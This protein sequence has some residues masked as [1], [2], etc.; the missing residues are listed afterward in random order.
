MIRKILYILV[1]KGKYFIF[2]VNEFLLKFGNNIYCIG[3]IK[4]NKH[5]KSINVLF[6]NKG[7]NMDKQT[8]DKL[9]V[10][11]GIAVTVDI[12]AGIVKTPSPG[13]RDSSGLLT[14]F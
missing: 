10:G 5:E 7:G 11:I 8:L 1:E 4:G 13:L 9:G 12:K 14:T 3:N 6:Q 2:I